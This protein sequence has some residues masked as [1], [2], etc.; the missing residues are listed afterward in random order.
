MEFLY[1]FVSGPCY[2]A[3]T[4]AGGIARAAGAEL[5]LT[6]VLA[7]GIFKAT[8]NPGPL[9][10]PA[11]AKWIAEDMLLWADFYGVA[12]KPTPYFPIRTLPLLRGAL[13]A[14]ERGEANR[15]VEA[16]FE[17][18]WAHERNLNEPEEV[19]AVLEAAGF[20]PKVYFA[21][22]ERDRIK[23]R[24]RRNT[25]DAVA[26][27]AFGVPT[28]FVEGKMFFGQ[29]RLPFVRNALELADPTQE[30]TTD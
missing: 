8:D 28:F 24:L 18:I 22:I 6:P 2:L 26:R 7:G 30:G 16:V 21:E 4:Q 14:E 10:I 27:G 20:D 13:V 17:A 3:S 1:D 23:D 11:K 12:F 15:Y 25:D 5:I 29:D 9:A 19:Q